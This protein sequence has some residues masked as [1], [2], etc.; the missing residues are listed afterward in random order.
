VT[1]TRFC[2]T[3]E[4]ADFRSC[5]HR[6]QHRSYCDGF[7]RHVEPVTGRT[8]ILEL[9]CEGCM[10]RPAEAGYL[11]YSHLAK[12]QAALDSAPGMVAIMWEDRTNG[13]RDA[14]SGGGG[15]AGPSWPLVE[16][17]IL[18]GWIVAALNNAEKVLNDEHDDTVD[19]RVVDDRSLPSS[20][21]VAEARRYA[22]AGA[23]RLDLFRDDLLG[24]KRG[25]EAAVR[26]TAFV[27]D[28]YRRFPTTERARRVAGIR[29]PACQQA[30][31]VW[32][33]PLMHR[34]DVVIRCANCR[35]EEPQEWLEQYAAVLQLRP[36]R[37]SL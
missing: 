7:A 13:I 24:S 12:F 15:H 1:G 37:G 11:C 9:P 22:R 26:L 29:C 23:S 2:I 19:L 20:S 27:A 10:P 4:L 16:S 36:S 5:L 14:N 32:T 17:R 21:T 3:N 18:A 30:Q 34:G 28:A 31:L 33:P 8:T 35:H 25:S 6:G